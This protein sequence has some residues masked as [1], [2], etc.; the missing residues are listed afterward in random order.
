MKAVA[1]LL[2]ALWVVAYFCFALSPLAGVLYIDVFPAIELPNAEAF[3][4][5]ARRLPQGEA[6]IRLLGTSGT[7]TTLASL[8][9]DLPRY[10][11]QAIDGLIV[12]S[13]S[14][15]AISE[16]LSTM[17]LADRQRLP[18]IGNARMHPTSQT[19]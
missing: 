19:K 6:G 4:P 12:P 1:L 13:S 17:A 8:H 14:M 15:R 11:R 16:R 2:F 18:C 7:V 10:D 9:L 3:A 5:L